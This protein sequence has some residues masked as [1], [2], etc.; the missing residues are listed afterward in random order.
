MLK[1]FGKTYSKEKHINSNRSYKTKLR[2]D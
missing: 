2:A 1:F